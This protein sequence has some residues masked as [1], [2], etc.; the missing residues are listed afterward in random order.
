V[1]SDLQ[2]ED[3]GL[4]LVE[5][6]P[7][8]AAEDDGAEEIDAVAAAAAEDGRQVALGLGI[9]FLSGFFFSIVSVFCKV[10]ARELHS[11]EVAWLTGLVRWSGMVVALRID[12]A[13][14]VP[15]A[16]IK[17]LVGI[18]CGFGALGFACA[19]YA[20][21]ALPLGDAAAILFSSPAWAAVMGFFIL[22]EKIDALG[23][24]AILLSIGGVVLISKPSFV[25]GN[26]GSAEGSGFASAVA[27][28][29]SVSSAAVQLLIRAIGKRGGERAAV[30]AHANALVNVVVA[31]VALLIVPGV[32]ILP[33][34]GP[35][36]AKLYPTALACLLG[37]AFGV[38]NQYFLNWGSQKAPAGLCAMMRN[39]DILFS[40][41]WQLLFFGVSPTPESAG[42]ALVIIVCSVSTALREYRKTKPPSPATTS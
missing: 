18:R 29:G 11:L 21:G 40:F 4:E 32:E 23:V 31:P 3:D 34:V 38:G 13:S 8:S 33:L 25:F 42:G 27:L 28:L 1:R 14:P 17:T 24:L 20:F 16:G 7:R 30:L 6:P 5:A 9:V 22:G 26:S 10:A 37:G 15:R 36:R 19:T 2:D 35:N 39:G 12:G 41:L